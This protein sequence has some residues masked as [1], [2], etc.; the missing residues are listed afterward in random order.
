VPFYISPIHHASIYPRFLSLSPDDFASWLS[1]E[2]AASTAMEMEIWYEME[3]GWRMLDDRKTLSFDKL[4]RVEKDTRL[5]DNAILFSFSSD[6]KGLYYW[7][8]EDAPPAA[9]KKAKHSVKG[10]VERSMRETRMKR[11]V[12]VGA[13]H[14]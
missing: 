13:L 2:A 9:E 8:G 14:Q 10:I 7:P 1:T 6:T 5:V 4:R 3:S 12:G 11:G